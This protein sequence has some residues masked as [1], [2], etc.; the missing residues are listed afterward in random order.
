MNKRTSIEYYLITT[1]LDQTWPRDE[2]NILMLGE[3]CNHY[4]KTQKLIGLNYSVFSCNWEDRTNLN[5]K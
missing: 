1:A 3:W 5:A 2:K 4:F